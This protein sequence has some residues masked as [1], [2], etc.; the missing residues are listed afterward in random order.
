MDTPELFM[1]RKPPSSV[2][3]NSTVDG[4]SEATNVTFVM[5]HGVGGDHVQAALFRELFRE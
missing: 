2:S 1:R 4:R 3:W 5:N